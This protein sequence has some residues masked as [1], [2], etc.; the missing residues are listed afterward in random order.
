MDRYFSLVESLVS[1]FAFPLSHP[2]VKDLPSSHPLIEGLH[3]VIFRGVRSGAY[4]FGGGLFFLFMFSLPTSRQRQG[5]QGRCCRW[6]DKA[7]R[8]PSHGLSGYNDTTCKRRSVHI[9]NAQQINAFWQITDTD[10]VC[11]IVDIY[12]L[13]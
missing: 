10:F 3:S 5:G 12:H 8:C 1:L 6:K 11:A 7:L 13:A 4:L 2:A 9:R